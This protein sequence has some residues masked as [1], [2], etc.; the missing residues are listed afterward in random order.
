MNRVY[1]TSRKYPEGQELC[2]DQ[3]NEM[4][5]LSVFKLETRRKN[6]STLRKSKLLLLGA[7]GGCPLPPTQPWTKAPADTLASNKEARERYHPKPPIP[8]PRLYLQ[9]LQTDKLNFQRS[10][11]PKTKFS[12][13]FIKLGIPLWQYV[14]I[15]IM[16]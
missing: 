2:Y 13:W 4:M 11:S 9:D 14:H 15:I 1:V 6:H 12:Q 3:E 5:E 7:G 16:N 8:S 10:L